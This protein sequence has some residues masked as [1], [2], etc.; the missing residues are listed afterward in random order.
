[1]RVR[2]DKNGNFKS[3]IDLPFEEIE[4]NYKILSIKSEQIID[5]SFSG[6]MNLLS[7]KYKNYNFKN[8]HELG[9]EFKNKNWVAQEILEHQALD[10]IKSAILLQ[11]EVQNVRNQEIVSH[12]TIPCF[13]CCRHS[14]ELKIKAIG[15]QKNIKLEKTHTLDDLWIK[16]I[17]EKIPNY[18]KLHAFIKDMD[19][20]GIH[21]KYGLDLNF[22]VPENEE[23]LHYDSEIMVSN[24]K[25]LFNILEYRF[26]HIVE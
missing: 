13:W 6:F 15:V 23:Y 18:N 12:Y 11:K 22:D 25:Y 2:Y 19:E 17:D 3:S 14:I 8:K 1:M 16:C 4:D 24:T 21:I 9:I 5:W 20:M 26:S 7:K 10:F